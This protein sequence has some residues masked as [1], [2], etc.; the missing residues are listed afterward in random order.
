MLSHT[1][2]AMNEYRRIHKSFELP[3]ILWYAGFIRFV[4]STNLSDFNAP[5]VHS[6]LLIPIGLGSLFTKPLQV[7]SVG[8]FLGDQFFLFKNKNDMRGMFY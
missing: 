8:L 3:Q 1:D 7:F 2:H 6:L 4:Y 5:I